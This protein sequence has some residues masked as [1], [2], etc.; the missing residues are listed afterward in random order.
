MSD[1]DCW[2][3]DVFFEACEKK[4]SEEVLTTTA[5]IN[6]PVMVLK[7]SA[8]KKAECQP[9]IRVR[10]RDGRLQVL[11]RDDVLGARYCKR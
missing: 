4:E 5:G 2:Q 10:V 1:G 9:Y 3:P 11:E 7:T 8:G 6:G